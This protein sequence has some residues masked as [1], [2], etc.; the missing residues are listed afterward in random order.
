[1]SSQTALVARQY[2]LREW[3]EQIQDCN[4]RPEDITI[5]QWCDQHDITLSNFY[6][7][8]REV[9]K[10]LLATVEDPA[11]E[12]DGQDIP[13]VDIS[14]GTAKPVVIH[15]NEFSSTPAAT[16]HCDSYCIDLYNSAEPAFIL[17]VLE[18]LG[19]AQ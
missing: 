2:R 17:S 6:Y 4:N 11:K 15:K 3:A 8:K 14:E 10:A 9:R 18:A 16:I 13:F 19:H 12:Q 5:A 1:M 7:R